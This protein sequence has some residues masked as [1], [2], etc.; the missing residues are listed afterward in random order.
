MAYRILRKNVRT[1]IDD[2][3]GGESTI[4]DASIMAADTTLLL[5]EDLHDLTDDSTL[6]PVGA[7]FQTPGIAT[8]RTVTARN[9]NKQVQIV[10]GA[11][12]TGSYTVTVN[13]VTTASIAGTDNAAA[14]KAAIEAL[15]NVDADAITVTGS[16]TAMSPF[17][18]EFG[19]NFVDLAPTVSATPTD[20]DN[21]ALTTLHAGAK[22]WSVTFSPAIATGAVPVDAQVITWLPQ[23]VEVKMGTGNLS[24]TENNPT[25]VDTDRG[26]LDGVRE[27]DEQP[28]DV[29]LVGTYQFLRSSSGQPITVYEAL[30]RTGNAAG[31]F[32]AAADPCE[33]YQVT[34]RVVHQPPCGSSQAEVCKFP[35]FIAN[36]REMSIEDATVSIVGI[37][38]ATKPIITRETTP[39]I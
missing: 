31:W 22:T 5:D 14:L 16:G 28:M 36:T 18:V 13:G 32:N 27:D 6:V 26:I 15:S 34:L 4:E 33:P 11:D 2:G 37:S 3:F 25:I 23:T 35:Y 10:I 1:F 9:A 24:W 19:G 39:V 21:F 29:N 38:V 17:I 30:T 8:V 7:R 20:L 12:T